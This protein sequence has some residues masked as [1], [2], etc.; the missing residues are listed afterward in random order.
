MDSPP[1][2]GLVFLVNKDTGFCHVWSN[3][4]RGDVFTHEMG[5]NFGLDHANGWYTQGND[6]T[7]VWQEYVDFSSAMSLSLNKMKRGFNPIDLVRLNLLL[8][9]AVRQ[10]LES[11]SGVAITLF[12]LYSDN[13]IR[14]FKLVDFSGV[15]YYI[16]YRQGTALYDSDIATNLYHPVYPGT[17]GGKVFI[18]RDDSV[19]GPPQTFCETVLSSGS[20][21]VLPDN[22]WAINYISN[23]GDQA[24]VMFGAPSDISGWTSSTTTTLS[25][26]VITTTTEL[27]TT[28][29]GQPFTTTE[30]PTTTTT[31]QPTTTT[32]QETTISS[33][34]TTSTL[35]ATTF[36]TTTT[37]VPTSAAPLFPPLVIQADGSSRIQ[38]EYYDQGAG[39]IY[40]S[41]P[42]NL[43]RQFRPNEPV[44]IEYCSDGGYN[45]GWMIPGEWI[46]YTAT[47]Q[48]SSFYTFRFRVASQS[49][50]GSFNLLVDGIQ[51]YSSPVVV[52]STFGWQKWTTLSPDGTIFIGAGQHT[53]RISTIAFGWNIDYFDVLA[54]GTVGGDTIQPPP[55]V[56]DHL[57]VCGN[58]LCEVGE[59]CKTCAMDC[60]YCLDTSTPAS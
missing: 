50:G 17:F 11:D 55:T 14:A 51:V 6:P 60:H 9:E 8:P 56:I 42:E 57:P 22:S 5:H 18:H 53:F 36:D 20:N 40:D 41:T 15:E 27:P 24:R 7:V 32:G 10:L 48:S 16:S 37:M 12:D 49:G 59:D 31:G 33:V 23:S 1:P 26:P 54:V 25:L 30:L 52:D 46:Q 4:L 3:N 44:D 29:T 19:H 21:F 13:P 34:L 43:G 38:A 39:S 45:V 35:Y 2:R 58:H 47:F 28:T